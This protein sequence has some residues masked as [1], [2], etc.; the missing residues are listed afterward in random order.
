MLLDRRA[1]LGLAGTVAATRALA[2]PLKVPPDLTET[3]TLWPGLRPA[4]APN[5]RV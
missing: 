3:V 1:V 5:C 2:A 4:R